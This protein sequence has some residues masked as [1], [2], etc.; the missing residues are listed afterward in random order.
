MQFD[1][2]DARSCRPAHAGRDESLDRLGRTGNQ[3]F[4]RSVRAVANP[5]VEMELAPLVY[6]EATV[7]DGLH[8]TF[9]AQP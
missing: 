5:A 7:T 8:K 4:H 1:V 2:G 3:G 9:D 6:D